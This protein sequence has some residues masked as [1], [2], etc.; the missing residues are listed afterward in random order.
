MPTARVAARAPGRTSCVGAIARPPCSSPP[1]SPC[2]SC[3]S[4][5]PRPRRRAGEVR[6]RGPGAARHRPPGSVGLPPRAHAR[7]LRARGADGRRLHRARRG[8]HE[9]RRP[10]R[11]ARERDLGHHRR[12]AHAGVR[13]RGTPT[14]TIDGVAVK[15]WF[16]EDFTLAELRTLR[17]EER[18]PAVREENTLYDGLY[19]VPTLDE[20]LELRARAVQRAGARHRRLH[21]DQAPHLLRRHRPVPRGAAA[22]RPATRPSW[23]ARLAGVHPVLRDRQPA[24]AGRRPA[25]ACRWC[26]CCRRS[27]APYDFVASG[28]TRTYADL[29]TAA[30][31]AEVA[32]Y[33]DGVGPEKSQVIP[34]D[35]DGNLGDADHAGGR[36]ARRRAARAPVHV[37]QREPVPARR[38]REGAAPDDY[39]RAIAEHLDLLGDRDRRACSPTTPTPAWCRGSCS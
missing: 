14:K 23:T 12:R 34:R 6:G 37:P 1:S 32:G 15:G 36:R 22:R 2:P 10:G 39:G 8:E 18:L 28:S 4:A 20:V 11:P 33:A 5:P 27:G 35:A 30:G 3:W 21:R 13:R 16:T 19:Q 26:S 38:L 7:L 29:T 9:G 31:L 25:C 17:A 24:G